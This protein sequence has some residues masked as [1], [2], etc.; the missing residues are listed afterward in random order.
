MIKSKAMRRVLAGETVRHS[1]WRK[2]SWMATRI[3][4]G[5]PKITRETR[6]LHQN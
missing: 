6:V 1:G 2:F 3:F 5:T 4:G